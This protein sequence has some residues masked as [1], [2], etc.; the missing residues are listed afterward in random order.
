MDLVTRDCKVKG[1]LGKRR[2]DAF[3][4]SCLDPIGTAAGLPCIN[5]EPNKKKLDTVL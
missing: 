3:S 4:H 2:I 5:L 1:K